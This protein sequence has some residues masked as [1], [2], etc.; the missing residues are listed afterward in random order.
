M[1]AFL[2]RARLTAE[3]CE[4]YGSAFTKDGIGVGDLKTMV[5]TDEGGAEVKEDF[6]VTS[7]ALRLIKAALGEEQS[8]GKDDTCSE[9]GG[10]GGGGQTGHLASLVNDLVHALIFLFI[11]LSI[12]CPTPPPG[13]PHARGENFHF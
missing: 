3:Q 8:E 13:M 4:E 1:H 6:G 7:R 9:G 12:A 2:V 11:R 5:S 10:G